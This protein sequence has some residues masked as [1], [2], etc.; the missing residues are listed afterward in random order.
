MWAGVVERGLISPVLFSLYVNDMPIPSRHVEL[1]LYVDDTTIIATSCKPVLL[2]NYLESYLSDLECWLRE[3][4]IAINIFKSMTMLFT[5]RHNQKPCPVLLFGEPV[6]W[7][8]TACYLGVT[9]DKRIVWQLGKYF[10]H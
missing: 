2:V 1:A 8:D 6:L 4:M 10:L 7:F 9:I 5:C 3:W